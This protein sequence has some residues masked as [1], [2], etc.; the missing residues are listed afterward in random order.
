MTDLDQMY[1]SNVRNS[2]LPSYQCL[3]LAA[4]VVHTM[5]K[6]FEVS[7]EMHMQL[8]DTSVCAQS[9]PLVFIVVILWELF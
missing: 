4:D 3:N 9:T 1:F 6:Q 5:T 8:T 7:D 2:I